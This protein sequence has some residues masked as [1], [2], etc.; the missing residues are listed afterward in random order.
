M[1]NGKESILGRLIDDLYYG[2]QWLHHRLR[3]WVLYPAYARLYRDSGP[4]VRSSIIVAGTGRSGTTWVAKLIS[5]Q[6]PGRVMFEPFYSRLV[7]DFAAFNY[8]QYMRPDEEDQE[9]QAYCQRVFTGAIR[10]PWIDR[11][12]DTLVSRLRIIKEIQAN[13]FLKWIHQRFPEIPLLFLIRHPCAVV[14]SRMRLA[15]DTDG[16]IGPFLAQPDLVA[17]H[18]ADKL[19]VIASAT[20]P[21]QKHAVVWCVRNLVPLRQFTAGELPI[22]FYENLCTQPEIEIPRVFQSIGQPHDQ[23]LF[24]LL[25]RPAPTATG[26][27]AVMRLR[28]HH[29]LARWQSQLSPRQVDGILSIVEAFGLDYLYGDSLVPIVDENNV[30]SSTPPAVS[31]A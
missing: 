24:R 25:D 20:T 30:T 21:E 16:D 5:S 27:S 3:K 31:H 1:K 13:L 18:L 4:D 29:K 17:D 8:F 10:R 7:P 22:I 9:L 23:S 6:L 14:K 28:G 12:V 2:R 26:D 19:E 11:M 15:W